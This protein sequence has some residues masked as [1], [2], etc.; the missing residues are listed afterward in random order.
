MSTNYTTSEIKPRGKANLN[1][2]SSKSLRVIRTLNDPNVPNVT[3]PET[4]FP[5]RTTDDFVR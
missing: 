3:S 2:A 5:A 1:K 4:V